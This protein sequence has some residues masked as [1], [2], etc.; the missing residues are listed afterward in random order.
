MENNERMNAWPSRWV[1]TRNLSVRHLR[2]AHH[3]A[4]VGSDRYFVSTPHYWVYCVYIIYIYVLNVCARTH[5]HISGG[6][7]WHNHGDPC[8]SIL[9][10][11]KWWIPPLLFH[12]GLSIWVMPFSLCPSPLAKMANTG[13]GNALGERL[14]LPAWDKRDTT[15]TWTLEKVPRHPTRLARVPLFPSAADFVWHWPLSSCRIID[16]C[17]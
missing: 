2:W 3:D 14:T 1:V 15:N 11:S 13:R 5:T 7:P 10:L 17:T 12:D 4:I 8:A 16:G 9:L 6:K